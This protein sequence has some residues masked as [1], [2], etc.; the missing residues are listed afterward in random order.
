MVTTW[1][2]GRLLNDYP[3]RNLISPLFIALI[4]PDADFTLGLSHSGGRLGACAEYCQE[5]YVH[6]VSDAFSVVF[7]NGFSIY[8]K[9]RPKFKCR[10]L[11]M[12]M[13]FIFKII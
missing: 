8:F 7:S 2:L 3:S 10:T 1:Q 9:L 6:K 5:N 12:Q 4:S 13:T 11:N